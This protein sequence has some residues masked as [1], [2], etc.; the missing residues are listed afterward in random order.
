MNSHNFYYNNRSYDVYYPIENN[1]SVVKALINQR[2]WEKKL[3]EIFKY[4]IKPN[5]IILDVG[6]YIG[7]HSILFSRLGKKVYAFEPQKL[8]GKCLSNTISSNNINNILFYNIA[9]YSNEGQEVFGSNN[10]GDSSLNSARKKK[11]NQNY[12]VKTKTIDSFN[13]DRVDFIKIDTEG[14]EFDVLKG[15]YKTI[16]NQRP[17]IVIEV[18]STN[19]KLKK[20]EHWCIDMG[21]TSTKIN[22]E[23]YLL[24]PEEFHY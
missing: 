3:V 17:V 6:A 24:L 15:G 14:S 9:L 1:S 4:Y 13:F 12:L 22:K 7:T 10:D 2:V 11:F 21:Y 20:L 18:F 19:V 16:I 23:N 5:H 8:V